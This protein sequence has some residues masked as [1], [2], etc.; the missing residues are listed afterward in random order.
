M[1]HDV[2]Q[3]ASACE[4]ESS[5]FVYATKDYGERVCNSIRKS[6]CDCYCQ[7]QAT[8][9]GKCNQIDN[10]YFR[11]YAYTGNMITDLKISKL[12]IQVFQFTLTQEKNR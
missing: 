6:G 11:L 5:L 4:G 9:D 8:P 2:N 10:S 3:C 12:T 7:T 1:L